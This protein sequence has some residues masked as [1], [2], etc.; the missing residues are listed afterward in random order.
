MNK[1]RRAQ[2]KDIE[3]IQQFIN[4]NFKESHVLS[5]NKA[6]FVFEYC[7][8]N[9]NLDRDQLINM[10]LYENDGTIQAILGYYNFADEYYLS[11][12]SAKAGSIFGLLILKEA[13]KVLT[14]KP[15]NVLGLS[16]QAQEL[17]QKL[18]YK[19]KTLNYQYLQNTIGTVV[20][21]GMGLDEKSLE[22]LEHPAILKNFHFYKKR[23]FSNPF[24]KYYY[25]YFPTKKLLYVYRKMQTPCENF[26]LI[27]DVL[28]DDNLI[29]QKDFSEIMNYESYEFL[30]IYSNKKFDGLLDVYE[31]DYIFSIY[32]APFLEQNV[33]LYYAY[34]SD[35]PLIFKL[36]GDQ[37][38]P[39]LLTKK[40][41]LINNFMYHYI[42]DAA[43]KQNVN[44]YI[45]NELFIEH[46]EYLLKY[47]QPIRMQ[48]L[49]SGN[50]D[51]SKEYF[52]VSFDDGY[53]EHYEFVAKYLQKQ[54]IEG[55][56]FVPVIEDE[57]LEVNKIHQ[58]LNWYDPSE[59]I[60]TIKKYESP[61]TFSEK[62]T[63]YSHIKSL[64]VP[65]II[66]I[67]RYLQKE[68]KASKIINELFEN[69]PLQQ[70]ENYYL[71]KDEMLKMNDYHL[72][73]NHT[74]LHK[75]LTDYTLDEVRNDIQNY[76][77]VFEKVLQPKTVSYPFGSVNTEIIEEYKTNG[78]VLGWTVI[79]GY[80]IVS[81]EGI[82]NG[83]RY[84]AIHLTE[85]VKK[86]KERNEDEI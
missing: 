52:I 78:Y 65:E 64:D 85:I 20:N 63:V 70:Y 31:S 51:E 2:Y 25:Y 16:E 45:D 62:Y 55:Q 6:L 24:Q 69:I 44:N 83:N 66:F 38:R 73:G 17:Y 36:R 50:F 60:T 5:I 42:R 4:D 56:F 75:H 39:G 27:V 9:N 1:F 57:L 81:E 41:A 48:D 84:D 68:A 3:R 35:E 79:P 29:E 74:C 67:K 7:D 21:K 14:D 11:L 32:N 12:W 76:E 43:V 61:Q 53:K 13:E 80:A 47:Y 34:N 82:L 23:F 18:G 77:L 33:K 59:I 19:V 10:F 22:K 37:E 26:L 8:S 40:Y 72:I 15:I 30:T 71:T 28:G 54:K 46:I 86:E 58:I 49:L